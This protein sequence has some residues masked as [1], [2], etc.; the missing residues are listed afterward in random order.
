MRDNQ[1]RNCELSLPGNLA[2]I[3][4]GDESFAKECGLS[5][6]F[7]VIGVKWNEFDPSLRAAMCFA[8]GLAFLFL[9]LFTMPEIRKTEEQKRFQFEIPTL[10]NA[11]EH[12]TI[13]LRTRLL[14]STPVL[15]MFLLTIGFFF[16]MK[17]WE[18]HLQA[19][20]K[21]STGGA[22]RIEARADRRS[23]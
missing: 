6:I 16:L 19:K 22:T 9:V 12:Q 14:I 20:E 2:A 7:G 18:H 11:S 1:A 17:A 15:I 4:A 8:W 13:S 5:V 21:G 10:L 23:S 3:D